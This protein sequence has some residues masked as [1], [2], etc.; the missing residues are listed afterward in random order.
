MLQTHQQHYM[1]TVSH[2]L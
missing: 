1:N 2:A